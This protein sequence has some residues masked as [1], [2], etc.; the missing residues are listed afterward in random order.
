MNMKNRS[1]NKR[2]KPFCERKN[3][4]STKHPIKLKLKSEA[5][6]KGKKK[7]GYIYKEKYKFRESTGELKWNIERPT[8]YW[9]NETASKLWFSHESTPKDCAFLEQTMP[10]RNTHNDVRHK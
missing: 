9:T 4:Y 6:W 7:L 10:K 5:R 3:V 8:N 1:G 2:L